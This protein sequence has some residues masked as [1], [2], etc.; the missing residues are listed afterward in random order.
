MA[1]HDVKSSN[2]LID[3]SAGGKL[4]LAD[5][6]TALKPGEE[7]VGFTRSYASPGKLLC[8]VI[9]WYVTFLSKIWKSNASCQSMFG[10][11]CEMMHLIECLRYGISCF[12]LSKM[13]HFH[14]RFLCES[15]FAGIS[16]MFIF[17]V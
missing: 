10:I 15:C 9:Y 5:F 12:G 14:F 13:K 17:P 7:T 16:R 3:A 6:G 1:H 4:L 8:L 11:D 2:I